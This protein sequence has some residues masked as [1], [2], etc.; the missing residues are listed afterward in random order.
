MIWIPFTVLQLQPYLPA[1][2]EY[3]HFVLAKLNIV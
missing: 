2:R 1:L 3:A